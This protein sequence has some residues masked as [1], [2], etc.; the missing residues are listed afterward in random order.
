MT[1]IANLGLVF[2]TVVGLLAVSGSALANELHVPIPYGT[3]QAAIDDANDGDVVIVADGT[4]TGTGNKNLNFRGRPIT[5]RSEKGP[6]HC[7]IDCEKSSRGFYFQSSEGPDS[8]LDGLTI[9]N[10]RV[11]SGGAISNYHS[12]PTIINCILKDNTATGGY[13]HGGGGGGMRNRQSNPIVINCAFIGNRGGDGGAMFNRASSHPTIINCTFSDN[14]ASDDAGAIFN[15][16]C[17]PRLTNSTFKGNSAG[18]YGGAI[19]NHACSPTFRNCTFSG[20]SGSKG[21]GMYNYGHGAY[22]EYRNPKLINCTFSGNRGGQGGGVY[23]YYYRGNTTLENCVLWGNRDNGGMDE[24]AQIDKHGQTDTPIINYS[25]IQGWTGSWGGIGNIGAD[26]CFADYGYWDANGLWVEGDYHL[27]EDSICINTGDPNFVPESNEVDIDGQPR[28]F[29]GR[30]DMGADEFVAQIEVPMRFTPQALNP[31]S[32]GNWMKAHSV[33]PEGY[34]VEDVDANSPA[35]VEPGGIESDH[36]NVFVNEGG[37][38]EV[39]AAFDR[40]AFC[41]AGISGEAIEV[42]VTGSFADSSQFYGTD[43]IKITSNYIEYLASLAFRWLEDDC[44]KPGWC[45]GL[46]LDQDSV[47]NLIDFAL[48]DGCCF[49][50]VSE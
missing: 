11:T 35:V 13:V 39:V 20:N 49:E 40:S 24:S 5:V 45:G 50:I 17:G 48:F 25:C 46:D 37:F 29:D 26:P 8:V 41:E 47:V 1:K 38:V 4:Y 7:I 31:G 43:T 3:I 16:W 2:V 14:S 12:H 21:G 10:G 42:T 33:L 44:G 22:D 15:D 19:V 23:S 28:V 18:R 32:K 36:I 27:L 34:A 9:M 30:V 6:E